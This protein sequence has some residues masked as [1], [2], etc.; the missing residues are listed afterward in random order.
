VDGAQTFIRWARLGVWER[1]LD[2]AQARGVELGMAFLGG[3]SARAH[4]KAAGASKK[5]DPERD[6][7]RVR[8][9]A[10]LVEG[11][12]PRPSWS[13][14]DAVAPLP[15]PAPGQAHEPPPAPGLPDRLP[16]APLWVAADR[17]YSSPAFR[18]RVWGLGARPAI[19]PK[20]NGAQVAC[21]DR[22]YANRNRVE[23]LRGRPQVRRA[24]A[25]R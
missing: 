17:G 13:P 5:G 1:L 4:A 9:L 25:T 16:D 24:V 2:L 22:A 20:R 21:P 19:P 12:A 10:A 11:M 23:R 8:R 14:M 3:A 6:V 7:V 15:S 18:G